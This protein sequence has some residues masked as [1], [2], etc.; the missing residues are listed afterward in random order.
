M[1]TSNSWQRLVD[2]GIGSEEALPAI[3]EEL[4][5]LSAWTTYLSLHRYSACSLRYPSH[6][7]TNVFCHS[8][9]AVPDKC[10][11]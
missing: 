10:W 9:W 7:C 1:G 6:A 11:A 4:L 3:Q 2:T 8:V 5:Q